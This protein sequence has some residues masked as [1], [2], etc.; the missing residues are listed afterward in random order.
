MENGKPVINAPNGNVFYGT[1]S[2][3][4]NQNITNE[5]PE[6]KFELRPI[7]DKFVDGRYIL[8]TLLVIDSKA[9]LKNLYV[10]A[11]APSI[12]T[13]DVTPQNS[14]MVVWG[15]SSTGQSGDKLTG[16]G[17]INIPNAFGN[18]VISVITRNRDK[19]DIVYNPE[20]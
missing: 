19:V 17:F 12:M 5:L 11:N 3:T 1:N 18:Y 6:P 10:E 16:K 13:F 4:V 8:Q 14:T 7:S 20:Y 2:G 9:P 15:H